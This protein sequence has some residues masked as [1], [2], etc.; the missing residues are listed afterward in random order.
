MRPR[1][2]DSFA[3]ET[4][5][6]SQAVQTSN[7]LLEALGPQDFA[8]I[9]PLLRTVQQRSAMSL[10]KSGEPIEAVYFPTGDVCSLTMTMEDGRV[11]EVGLSGREGVIGYLAGFGE[12]NASHDA[13][14]QVPGGSL[15]S[16]SPRD[17]RDHMSRNG[18]FR[19]V[20]NRYMLA[21]TALMSTSVACNALHA[22]EE[23]CAR[24]LLHAHDR[25]GVAAFDLS[26]EFLAMMLGV[27]RPTATI[28][29]GILQRAGLIRY[30]RGHMNIVDRARLEQASCECY[31]V[32][33]KH[34][35]GL[36]TPARDR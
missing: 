13:M 3:S 34:F 27:R 19:D 33:E 35:E 36:L 4:C 1:P 15:L 7:A 25:M 10:L 26:H 14:V 20:I 2:T 5:V 28:V 17:F 31:G 23:R 18:V 22:A 16:M 32:I 29:A 21:M 9:E 11:A 30:S 8:T 6:A 12:I 24:W